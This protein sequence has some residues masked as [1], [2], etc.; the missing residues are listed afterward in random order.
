MLRYSKK[1]IDVNRMKRQ[2]TEWKKVS[3]KD[4]YLKYRR[5]KKI[6]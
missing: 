2:H 4:R 6:K 3:A 5:I 1:K